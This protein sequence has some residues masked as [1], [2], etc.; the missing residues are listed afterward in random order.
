[1]KMEKMLLISYQKWMGLCFAMQ[2][3]FIT[4]SSATEWE[5]YCGERVVLKQSRVQ[6][7]PASIV[8]RPS[9]CSAYLIYK[10]IYWAERREHMLPL[11]ESPRCGS[12]QLFG[13]CVSLST[14]T[15]T[16]TKTFVVIQ[17]NQYCP[18]PHSHV[19][20]PSK[21]VSPRY[22]IFYSVVSGLNKTLWSSFEWTR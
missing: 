17:C 4:H 20:V 13:F 5:K 14:A 11:H 6:R 16:A 19:H 7:I 3:L 8:F 10:S 12:N 21:H 22:S 1:M 15:A 9:A 18:W 2:S